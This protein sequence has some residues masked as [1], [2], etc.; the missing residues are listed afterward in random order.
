MMRAMHIVAPAAGKAA[1]TAGPFYTDPYTNVIYNNWGYN[2]PVRGRSSQ[3]GLMQA[4][5]CPAEC[6]APSPT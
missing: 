3:V 1:S 2:N 6:S 5:C 4:G